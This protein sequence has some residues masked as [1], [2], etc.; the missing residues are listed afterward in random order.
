MS[1]TRKRWSTAELESAA[2]GEA[3]ESVRGLATEVLDARRIVREQRID[4]DRLAQHLA[5]L[6][7]VL[8]AARHSLEWEDALTGPVALKRAIEAHDAATYM[9]AYDDRAS[10]VLRVTLDG[11]Q[12]DVVRWSESGGWVD[13]LILPVRALGGVV[14]TERRFGTVVTHWREEP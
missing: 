14:L 3:G 4:E 13:A 12:V 10:A 2:R 6:H 1:E 8:A 9:S 5:S 11:E 7:A